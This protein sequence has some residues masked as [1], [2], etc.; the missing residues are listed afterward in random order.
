M[1]TKTEEILEK[2]RELD[3]L[4]EDTLDAVR[5]WRREAYLAKTG[6]RYVKRSQLDGIVNTIDNLKT[7]E[8]EIV[9]EI[10]KLREASG[11]TWGD[12]LEAL[13]EDGDR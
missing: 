10:S 3:K 4:Y 5:F 2:A 8:E 6:S 9:D 13:A 1:T 7:R 11:L 12:F